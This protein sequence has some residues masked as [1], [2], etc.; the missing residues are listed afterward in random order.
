[1]RQVDRVVPGFVSDENL[2]SMARFSTFPFAVISTLIAAFYKSNHSAGGTGYLLIVAFDVVLATVVAPLFGAFYTSNPSPR[3][4][5]LS[6]LAGAVARVTM[7]FTLPK[8]GFLLIPFGG[9]EFLD[10]GTAASANFPVFFDEPSD[11]LWD[12][13][14]EE[15]NQ[16]R[17]EDYTGVDSIA[18]FLLSIIVFVVFQGIDD[19]NGTPSF[20]FPGMTP[21]EKS[22]DAAKDVGT[23]YDIETKEVAAHDVETKELSKPEAPEEVAANVTIPEGSGYAGNVVTELQNGTSP[24]GVFE[25]DSVSL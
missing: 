24:A 20:S 21:Y 14:A 6:I 7:E 15:C 8:D 3:A 19:M 22:G 18:A 1:M 25:A 2:L 4:A 10:Y 9:D 13:A 16:R 23:A 17:F 5:L 11:L 12:P